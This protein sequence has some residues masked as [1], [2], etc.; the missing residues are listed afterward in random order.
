M[1]GHAPAVF[2]TFSLPAKSAKF[3]FDCRELPSRSFCVKVRMRTECDRDEW[4]FIL[5]EDTARFFSPVIIKANTSFSEATYLPYI[6]K[7]N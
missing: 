6:H 3:N 2:F 5:V 1:F 4:A 7:T